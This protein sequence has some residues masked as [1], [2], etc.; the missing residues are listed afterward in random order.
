MDNLISRLFRGLPE[1]RYVGVKQSS[2]NH[3]ETTRYCIV[4]LFISLAKEVAAGIFDIR[5]NF[6][7]CG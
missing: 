5:N 4:S 1:F 6:E 7:S 2:G 3:F